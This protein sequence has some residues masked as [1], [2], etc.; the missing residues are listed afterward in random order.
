MT[1][2]ATCAEFRCAVRAISWQA[3]LHISVRPPRQPDLNP[4]GGQLNCGARGTRPAVSR[5]CVAI[6]IVVENFPRP[7]M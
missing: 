7:A 4:R 1:L 5:L 2:N 3:P 6:V